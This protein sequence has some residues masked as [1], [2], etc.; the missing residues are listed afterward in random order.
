MTQDELRV[1]YNEL[2]V[3]CRP[4]LDDLVKRLTEAL[5]SFRHVDRVYGRIK[6]K[7]SFLAKVASDPSGYEPPFSQVEDFIAL[8]VL[9]RFPAEANEVAD[10]LKT[11]FLPNVE[12]YYKMPK[13]PNQF[14]YEGHQIVQSLPRLQ[15]KRQHDPDFPR[16]FEIQVKTLFMHA[17][18]EAEHY[19]RYERIRRGEAVASDVQ[20]RLAWIAA[21]SWGSDRILSEL[22]S[23]DSAANSM[24]SDGP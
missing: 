10:Y 24:R 9:V 17:W 3:V 16:V 15:P 22:V 1:R 2:A 6:S 11:N 18:A 14:G 8:R 12:D 5:T 7:D 13:D 20:R 23:D 21:S 19:I 4:I